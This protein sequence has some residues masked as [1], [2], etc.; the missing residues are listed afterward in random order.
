MQRSSF[1]LKPLFLSILSGLLLWLG[2]PVAGFAGLL[3]IAFVPL[4][5]LEQNFSEQ[6]TKRKQ[7][8]LF[9][10]FYL[11]F[12][13]WNLGTTWWIYNSTGVGAV[14]ALGLNALLMSLVWLL[15]HITKRKLGRVAGYISL[16]VYWISF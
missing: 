2:W 16:V 10:Y 15:F 11:T 1:F 8:K 5:L 7:L 3:F 9:S 6:A 13:I 14:L 4:L 12:L